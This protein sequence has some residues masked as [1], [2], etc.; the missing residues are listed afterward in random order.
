MPKQV[1]QNFT[2]EEI[3]A[4]YTLLSFRHAPKKKK[5]KPKVIYVRRSRRHRRNPSRML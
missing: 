4:A 3:E 2:R 1:L 5:K